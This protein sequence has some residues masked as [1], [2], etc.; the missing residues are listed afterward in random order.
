MALKAWPLVNT[1][2][3]KQPTKFDSRK[4]Q[5]PEPNRRSLNVSRRRGESVAFLGVL[6][7][8]ATQKWIWE[9][10][11]VCF[12]LYFLIIFDLNLHLSATHQCHHHKSSA[13]MDVYIY[14]IY[15]RWDVYN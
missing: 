9:A 6:L 4:P 14:I 8:H 7:L 1:N 5:F 11:M 10:S 13:P 15:N 2:E 12:V 3:L